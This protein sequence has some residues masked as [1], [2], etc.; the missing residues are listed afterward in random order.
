M[1]LSNSDLKIVD[2]GKRYTPDEWLSWAN[3]G[4]IFD[5]I[6]YPFSDNAG[7]IKNGKKIPFHPFNLY[8]I[9]AGSHT[10]FYIEENTKLYHFY[11]DFVNL[12]P[13][14]TDT[15]IEIDTVSNA[16]IKDFVEFMSGYLDTLNITRFDVSESQSTM[17]SKP[18]FLDTLTS[19]VTTLMHLINEIDPFDNSNALA[20]IPA[21]NH[22]RQNYSGDI[23]IKELAELSYFSESHFT[24][25]F[26]TTFDITPYQYLKRIRMNIAVSMLKNGVKCAKI[27]DKVGY[28]SVTAFSIAFKKYFGISPSE[29]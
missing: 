5:K 8:Y 12:S 23:N 28:K 1:V 18:H 14:I 25:K 20:L 24:R 29:I 21:V 27:Y 7:Y 16:H 26:T 15:I 4:I 13:Y 2:C 11:V 22:I 9:P 10:E 19:T 17:A 3:T 6:Y